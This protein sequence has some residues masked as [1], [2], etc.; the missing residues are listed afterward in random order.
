[1]HMHAVHCVRK[2]SS[3]VLISLICCLAA[4]RILFRRFQSHVGVVDSWIWSPCLV[5]G[6]NA[7]GQKG[8]CIHVRDGNWDFVN[9]KVSVH[10]SCGTFV[11]RVCGDRQDIYVSCHY[12][13][14]DLDD[15]IYDCLAAVQDEDVRS[16][17]LFVCDLN[18]HHQEWLGSIRPRIVMVL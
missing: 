18:G 12:G 3:G 7:S 8:V 14:N 17:F 11:L 9:W 10:A 1:M 2:V 13:N 4:F 5:S 15:Q 6:K 16:S